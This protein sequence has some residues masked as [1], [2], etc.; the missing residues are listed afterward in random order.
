MYRVTFI[1][2]GS[3][4]IHAGSL[5]QLALIYEHGFPPEVQ[6]DVQY[7]LKLYRDAAELGFVPAIY[8]LGHCFEFGSILC[9]PDAVLYVI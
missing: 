7:S 9:E 6:R 8:H 2:Q 3:D 1:N 5:Y 4:S